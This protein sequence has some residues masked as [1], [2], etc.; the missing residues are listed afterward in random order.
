M[1][2]DEQKMEAKE[3]KTTTDEKVIHKILIPGVTRVH[4]SHEDAVDHLNFDC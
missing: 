2:E 1:N 3:V 4:S